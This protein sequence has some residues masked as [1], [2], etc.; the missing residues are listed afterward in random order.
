MVLKG[1]ILGIAYALVCLLL[2]FILYKLGLPKKYTRKL[3]HI[4]VGF[5]WVILYTFMGAGVHF[6]AVCVTFLILLTVAYKGKL[7]PMISSDADNAPGTVYYALAMTGVAAVGCF[8]PA[9]MLPFG[10]GVMCTSIGD[11]MA[12]VVGQLVTAKNPKIYKN[13][14]LLGS[15]T[16]LVASGL[17]A[18]AL[19]H[20]FSMNLSVWHCL[21]IALLSV[22]LELITPYG[23]D[24]VSITWGATALG[25][26]FMYV[27]VIGNYLAPILLTPV[28]ILFAVQKR[29]LTKDGI[30]AAILLDIAV[31]V[32]FGNFGFLILSAFFVGAVIVDKIKNKNKNQSRTDESAKGECRDYMQVLA[33]GMVAFVVAIAFIVTGKRLFVV[34]FVASLAEAFSD[35][36]ASGMGVFSETTFD[37]FRW[38]KCENGM[39][40]G[41]SLIG[42]LSSLFCAVL[43]ASVAYAIGAFGFGLTE[44]Y[45]VAI[46]AFLGAVFDS[47]LGSLLQI[48]Y[49]CYECGKITEREEHCGVPTAR[50]SGIRIIDNDIVNIISCSF[51]AVVATVLAVLL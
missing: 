36:A 50:Y 10:I 29:A 46:S 37:P 33:N 11:G 7:M 18:Y 39:S 34:P 13:K 38:R 43:I 8:V 22:E 9:V 21:A 48:K 45:I 47:A 15:L 32:A 17:S 40:G 2:S 4:L 49:K 14:T 25:Y 1:Y 3:V 19:S 42:T 30:I 27:G 51:S 26:S 20:V 16:N 12:G 35:T 41:M 28:I 44:F 24:N 5:E 6:L 23:L 31:S